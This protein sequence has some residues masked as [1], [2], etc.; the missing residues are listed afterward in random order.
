HPESAIRFLGRFEPPGTSVTVQLNH[1]MTKLGDEI[2]ADLTDADVV[3]VTGDLTQRRLEIGP[4]GFALQVSQD[5]APIA[6]VFAHRSDGVRF[7]RLTE[8]IR[9]DR[10]D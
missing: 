6:P 7:L 2:A 8:R 4:P 9:E 5:R 3:D 1:P 10:V